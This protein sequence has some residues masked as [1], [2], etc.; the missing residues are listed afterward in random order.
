MRD[1]ISVNPSIA[2]AISNIL[3]GTLVK[4]QSFSNPRKT[5]LKSVT[6]I[7]QTACCMATF[8]S[9]ELLLVD[10]F[11]HRK[12]KLIIPNGDSSQVIKMLRIN[13]ATDTNK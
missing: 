5:I 12:I 9:E 3:P 8:N 10:Y 4:L 2:V 11:Q 1:E 6:Q 7:G 13:S